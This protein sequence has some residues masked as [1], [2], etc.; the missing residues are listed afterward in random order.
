[1]TQHSNSNRDG[2]TSEI[3]AEK[4]AEYL[5]EHPG[6]FESHPEVLSELDIPHQAGLGTVSLIERQVSVL[7]SENRYLKSRIKELVAVARDND[8][9]IDKLHNLY[10]DLLA[11]EDLDMFVSV[12]RQHLSEEF[13]V[14]KIAIALFED[15]IDEELSAVLLFDRNDERL[16]VFE[17]VLKRR[18]PVCGR[19]HRDQL[20]VLFGVDADA[21]GSL[22]TLPLIGAENMGLIA[23]GS[24]DKDR[25]RAGMSTV[26]LAYMT[27]MCSAL[28]KQKLTTSEL[29]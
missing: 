22:A 24:L 23:L 7:R 18:K 29:V 9:L 2:K 17:T 12:L 5:R 4:V 8:S 11:S 19:Y 13:N 27:D 25:F 28:L 26:F 21:I 14:D 15:V 6:F 10:L 20:R 1:M 3:N 16:R